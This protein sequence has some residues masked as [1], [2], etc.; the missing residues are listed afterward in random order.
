MNW[1]RTDA[2]ADDTLPGKLGGMFPGLL[3]SLSVF[4]SDFRNQ[5]CHEAVKIAAV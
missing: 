5:Y 2:G 3:R 4:R 1:G